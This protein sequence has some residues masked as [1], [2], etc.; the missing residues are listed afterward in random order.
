MLTHLDWR[1]IAVPETPKLPGLGNILDAQSWRALESLKVTIHH[2]RL[3]PVAGPNIRINEV[4]V[5]IP[6]Q[7][8][9]E[10]GNAIAEKAKARR[11][12]P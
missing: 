11:E 5:P 8:S 7:G 3:E 9:V 10:S 12:Q 2:I 1:T 6:G 4:Y